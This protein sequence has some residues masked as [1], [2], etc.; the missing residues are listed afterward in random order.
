MDNHDGTWSWSYATTD[1]GSGT[2]QVKAEDGEH[3]AATD[4]FDWSAKNVPPTA[5]FNAPSEVNEGSDINISLSAV[6][7]PGTADTFSYHFSCDGGTTWTAYGASASHSCPTTDN[8]SKTVKGQVKDDDGGESPEYSQA[9]TVKNVPPTATFNA[10]SE[11]NEGSDINISLSAVVDPGTADTFS[12]HFSCDGGTTWTAYGASASHSCPTTDNGSKTV[13]GQVKDDDGG[14]SPEYSQAVTV[15]NVPPTATFNAP[16]EVNEGRTSTSRSRLLSIRVRRTRSATA[17]VVTAVRPGRLMARARAIAARRPTTARRRSRVRSRT[18]TAAEPGY[19][20]AVTVKNVPPTIN[21]FAIAKPAGAACTLATN[22][23]TVSFTVS[24]PADQAA[25]PI[26]GSI[27]WGDGSVEAI[28][29]RTISKDHYYAPG[30]PYTIIVTV[31]DGDGGV[32]NAGDSSTAFSL[33]YNTSGILQPINTTGSRSAFKIGSTI[34]VKIK[35]TD[36]NGAPVSG[37]TLHVKLQKLDNSANPVNETGE[38]SVPDVGDT[39]RYDTSGLQYIYNLSTKRSQLTP[40]N[41]DLTVG[42]YR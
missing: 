1:N 38:V 7:D 30:G 17:S 28:A 29:G 26:T 25:D 41:A 5:T 14:E 16:S 2:V 40:Q 23:V 19:S 33:L 8:G 6:V 13:K 12:Y 32:A 15:K 34:P 20:Q 36:C 37:L 3:T 42:S 21:N 9:V 35:V 18:T 11:V 22:K 24:D 4:S 39:M 10:P 31:N 27:D